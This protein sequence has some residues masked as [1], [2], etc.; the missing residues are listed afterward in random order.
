MK[1]A[2]LKFACQTYS[3]Q[4]DLD[5]YRGEYRHMIT[6]AAEAGFAGF[7]PELFM[8]GDDWDPARL[9]DLMD[10][11]GVDLAALV[12]AEP[13]RTGTET[14]T[15]RAEADLVINTAA[16]FPDTK[17]V[18]V[19]LPSPDR[20][21]LAIRQQQTMTCLA[22]VAD[23]A[24]DAGLGCAFHPNSPAGSLFRTAADYQR[25][26]DLLPETIGFAPD[27]GH[28]AKG[29]MDPIEVIKTWRD[30]VAHVHIKDLA[31]DGQWAPTGGG[32]IDIPG[33]LRLLA[34]T[35]YPG[36]VTFEDESPQA[37]ADPDAATRSNAEYVR[38]LLERESQG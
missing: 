31:A 10:E 13:W 36:W 15:E 4:L 30:R 7:E 25:I 2:D 3:W 18:L 34:E 38:G 9:K 37:A 21:D 8:L 28:I 32:I 16:R 35:G 19:P 1:L 33:V 29:G 11:A 17:I 27:V 12:L 22:A 24:A 20:S 26:A 23:R 5:R 6:V 14:D